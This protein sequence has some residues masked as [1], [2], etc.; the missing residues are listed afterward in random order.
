M[1]VVEDD[2]ELAGEHAELPQLPAAAPN[3]TFVGIHGRD[4]NTQILYISSGVRDALGFTP[5]HMMQHQAKEFIADS[6]SN[7]YPS[8]YLDK[9]GSDGDGDEEDDEDEANAYVMYMNIKTASGTP[10]LMRV[11]SFKCDNCVIVVTMAFPERPF[12]DRCELEVQMLDGAMKRLNMTRQEKQIESRRQSAAAQGRHMPLYFAR[13]KQIKAAFVL[14]NPSMSAIESEETGRRQ[15][16]PLVVFATGSISRIID[17]DNTDLMGYPFMKLVAP[18]DVLHVGKFF[19][20]LSTSTDVLFE[21]FS[22]LQRPQVIEG[23]VVT[24]EEQNPRV[25]VECLG[26]NVQDGVALLMRKLR[27]VAPPKRD[28]MGNYIHSKIHAV[29]DEGG[30]ISLAEMISSDPETSDAPEWSLV[31]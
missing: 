13:N 15:T 31:N 3:P 18:E 9:R 8:I 24:E 17:A 22:M 16:G 27:T 28:T 26:A 10:V 12:Q 21:K 19:D 14:E 23:D 20:R 7:T 6:Y 30:Y 4:E 2:Q 1:T 25:M 5:A 29:D 11:T